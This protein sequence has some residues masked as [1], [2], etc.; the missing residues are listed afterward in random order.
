MD[1]DPLDWRTY[2]SRGQSKASACIGLDF[3]LNFVFCLRF[4]WTFHWNV[5][6]ACRHMCVLSSVMIREN[7]FKTFSC[8]SCLE[9]NIFCFTASA[10][11]AD[12]LYPR[13]M[14]MLLAA[15]RKLVGIITDYPRCCVFQNIT[16]NILQWMLHIPPLWYYDISMLYPERLH[17]VK[18]V[19]IPASFVQQ[20]YLSSITIK[21]AVGCYN[22]WANRRRSVCSPLGE[23]SLWD[24]TTG[25]LLHTDTSVYRRQT[26]LFD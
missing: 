15:W 3:D 24:K 21:P 18:V 10:L 1:D 8:H 26:I 7:L 4:N 19:M 9:E 12:G 11:S 17:R 6:P 25:C 2:A 13:N 16:L 5:D 14:Q 20:Q 22:F 23:N